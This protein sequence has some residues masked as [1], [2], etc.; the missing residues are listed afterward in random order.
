MIAEVDGDRGNVR[1]GNYYQALTWFYAL[2]LVNSAIDA[3]RF[4]KAKLLRA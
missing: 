3:F 2:P 4:F 1:F